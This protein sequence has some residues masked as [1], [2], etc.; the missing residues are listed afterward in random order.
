MQRRVTAASCGCT[1]PE[2]TYLYTVHTHTITRTHI[3]VRRS[4]TY[5]VLLHDFL[6]F[7]MDM[8]RSSLFAVTGKIVVVTGGGSG[9]GLMIAEGM[10]KNGARRVYLCSRKNAGAAAAAMDVAHIGECIAI[11]SDLSTIEGVTAVQKELASREQ[12]IHV[13]VNN[14]GTNWCV[15]ACI[16]ENW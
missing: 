7:S 8:D 3:P 10:L 14:S 13:L 12:S 5:E 15:T 2:C 16:P 9:I 1:L 6:L 11:E 4:S